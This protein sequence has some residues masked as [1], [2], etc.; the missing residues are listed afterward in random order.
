MLPLISNTKLAIGAAILAAI[1]G[2][3][4]YIAVL[5]HNVER[6]EA[7]INKQEVVIIVDKKSDDAH[8]LSNDIAMAVQ[9]AKG[10]IYD[11]EINTTIGT[12]S[13]SF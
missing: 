9:K 1:A 7:I 8:V 5:Q 6:Q 11:T 13:I 3:W 4:I 2:V 10:V 12:H